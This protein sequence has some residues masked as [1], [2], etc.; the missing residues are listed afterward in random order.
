MGAFSAKQNMKYENEIMDLILSI[1]K[2]KVQLSECILLTLSLEAGL[3]QKTFQPLKCFSFAFISQFLL[4]FSILMVLS[5]CQ[6][7][8]LKS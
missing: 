5:L 3:A 2:S 6:L 7:S 1:K 8:F 4:T